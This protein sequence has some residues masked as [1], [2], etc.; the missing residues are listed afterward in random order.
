[1]LITDFDG[2]LQVIVGDNG[3]GINP[4]DLDE[5]LLKKGKNMGQGVRTAF[6]LSES[7]GGS[8]TLRS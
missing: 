2:Y 1:L 7:N 6:I 8:F 5:L 4:K 3:E